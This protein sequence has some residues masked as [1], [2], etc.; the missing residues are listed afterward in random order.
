MGGLEKSKGGLGGSFFNKS[1]KLSF[2]MF[3]YYVEKGVLKFF[4]QLKGVPK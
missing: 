4:K 2:T 3:W 1:K